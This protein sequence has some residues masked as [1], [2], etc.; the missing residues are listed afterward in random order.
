MSSNLIKIKSGST[1]IALIIRSNFKAK[2]NQFLTKPTNPLQLGINSY[3]K[4][5]IVKPHKHRKILK[6][7]HQNQEF[8]FV[9]S[10]QV[11]VIF[12][13]KGSTFVKNYIL[14]PGDCLLQISGGHSFKFLKKSVLITIKQGPYHGKLKEKIFLKPNS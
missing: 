4:N 13:Y 8:I 3:P 6:T 2:P 1:L 12:F 11:K 7:I 5:H 9:K 10:G 14:N